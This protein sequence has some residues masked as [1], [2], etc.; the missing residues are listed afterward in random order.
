MPFKPFGGGSGRSGNNFFG[1]G[2]GY[3]IRK[4]KTP[5]VEDLLPGYKKNMKKWM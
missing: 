5:R 4:W 1:L 2:K 3:R